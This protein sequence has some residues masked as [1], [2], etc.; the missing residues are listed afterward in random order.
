ML[1]AGQDS[2]ASRSEIGPD[3][4]KPINNELGGR[5]GPQT[6]NTLQ[7]LTTKLA[8]ARGGE[9]NAATALRKLRLKLV[10]TLIRA[11]ADALDATNANAEQVSLRKALRETERE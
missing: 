7:G 5:P 4:V 10:R 3:T 11:E 2:A 9:L 8:E 1:R 6:L